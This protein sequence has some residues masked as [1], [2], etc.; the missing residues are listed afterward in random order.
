MDELIGI[1]IA[2]YNAEEYINECINSL[3]KQSYENLEIILIDDGSKDSSGKICDEFSLIDTRIKV[4]HKKN[5]G[6]VSAWKKGVEISKANYISFIDSDDFVD[7]EYIENMVN[8]LPADIVCTNFYAYYP[9]GVSKKMYFPLE[10]GHYGLDKLKNQVF[11]SLLNNG[12]FESRLM[13]LSRSG[14]I[15][16]K[17]LIISNLKYC[18]ESTTYAEDINIMFPAVLDSKDIYII[19]VE[20]SGY[21]YRQNPNSMLHSFD[22]NRLKSVLFVYNSLLKICEDRNVNYLK[23]Q[24]YADFLAAAVQCYKNE[25]LNPNGFKIAKGNL[26]ILVNSRLFEKAVVSVNWRNYKR[27]LNRLIVKSLI[28]C[29]SMRFHGFYLILRNL[30]YLRLR[31]RKH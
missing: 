27:M 2:V 14:K 22:K 23:P 18:N 8:K 16:K 19:D 5:G 1:I 4:I 7:R 9:N 24:V 17:D 10:A 28:N 6:L 12:E 26:E 11:P 25:L 13:N 20:N 30:K 3:L 29:G 21:Y 31:Q 15:I